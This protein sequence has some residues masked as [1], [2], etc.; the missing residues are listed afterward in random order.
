M[1]Q[2]IRGETSAIASTRRFRRLTGSSSEATRL[3]IAGSSTAGMSGTTSRRAFPRGPMA[4]STSSRP[5]PSPSGRNA[6]LSEVAADTLSLASA[7]APRALDAS[8]KDLR[9]DLN[10]AVTGPPPPDAAATMSAARALST[11]S[12]TVGVLPRASEEA[13]LCPSPSFVSPRRL[14]VPSRRSLRRFGA[15]G[16]LLAA[17]KAGLAGCRTAVPAAAPAVLTGASCCGV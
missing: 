12:F 17:G 11:D 5:V 8:R 6:T 10:A 3:R 7:S 14:P 1:A 4:Y 13:P 9:S 16:R 15:L 2:N